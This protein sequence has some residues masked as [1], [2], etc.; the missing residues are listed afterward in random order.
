MVSPA[1]SPLS[2]ISPR[3]LDDDEQ[4]GFLAEPEEFSDFSDFSEKTLVVPTLASQ[5]RRRD[6]RWLG[7]LRDVLSELR[8]IFAAKKIGVPLDR[9]GLS[10]RPN[11]DTDFNAYDDAGAEIALLS[12]QPVQARLFW[13]EES[14]LGEATRFIHE[15]LEV[16]AV[17][18]IAIS[19]NSFLDFISINNSK[20]SSYESILS[21][22]L[23]KI[24]NRLLCKP[25][26]PHLIPYDVFLGTTLLGAS[27]D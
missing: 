18:K 9:L 5:P 23:D 10:L 11:D 22:V 19:V 13:S 16:L 21:G 1:V 26:S 14:W 15:L 3:W 25:N 27:T 24:R 12:A 4:V 2:P 6:V 17:K 7:K 20:K 8:S